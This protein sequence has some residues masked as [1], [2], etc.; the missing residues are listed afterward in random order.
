MAN[1]QQVDLFEKR[2]RQQDPKGKRDKRI[3]Q[4]YRQR[5]RAIAQARRLLSRR[6]LG[7][8]HRVTE[9]LYAASNIYERYRTASMVILSAELLD[10]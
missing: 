1:V 3:E 10:A 2:P 6:T 5:G 4:A 9:R 7:G 8:D